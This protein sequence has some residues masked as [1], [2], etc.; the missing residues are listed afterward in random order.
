MTDRPARRVVA[1]AP[2][3]R[4][5]TCTAPGGCDLPALEGRLSC[6]EHAAELELRAINLIANARRARERQRP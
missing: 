6:R 4:D 2:H 5:G 3:V 1:S